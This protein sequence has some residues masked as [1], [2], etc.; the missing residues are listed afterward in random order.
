M[1]RL[2]FIVALVALCGAAVAQTYVPGHTRNDGTYV[3][4]H[5][6]AAPDANRYNNQGSQTNGG[7]QRDEFSSGTGATNKSNP[8]YGWRDNDK[9]GVANAYD[10][11]PNSRKSW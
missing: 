6:R 1:K 4:G 9:D 2:I 8:G 5:M 7:R 3:Q 10:R 11:K